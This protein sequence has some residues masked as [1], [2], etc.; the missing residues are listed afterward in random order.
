MVSF[1]GG[2][3]TG[4]IVIKLYDLAGTS[5]VYRTA[6][7]GWDVTAQENGYRGERES[8]PAGRGSRRQWK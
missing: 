6:M 1:V 5:T 3:E 7:S 4:P 2:V 8:A